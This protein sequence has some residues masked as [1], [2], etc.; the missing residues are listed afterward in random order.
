MITGEI[1]MSRKGEKI[2][3]ID[4]WIGGF[5][6]LCILSIVWLVQG[7]LTVDSAVDKSYG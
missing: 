7:K 2:G 6:W 5:I 4:G 1:H 3:W